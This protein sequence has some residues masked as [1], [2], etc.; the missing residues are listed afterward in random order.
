MANNQIFRRKPVLTEHQ[1][2]IRFFIR[3]SV[4]LCIPLALAIFLLLNRSSLSP[5]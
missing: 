1:K 4:G 5:Q 2:L 3:L